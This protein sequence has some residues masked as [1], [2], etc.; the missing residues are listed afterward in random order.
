MTR[1]D[2]LLKLEEIF[3]EVFDDETID[4]TE[5]ITPD[6]IED[7]DSIGNVYLTVEI[8]EELHISLGDD[9]NKISNV[10][11]IID[12]IINRLEAING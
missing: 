5:E 8:E 10:K 12:L 4:L 3:R 7:W 6:D 11:D 9:M 2:I 1:E